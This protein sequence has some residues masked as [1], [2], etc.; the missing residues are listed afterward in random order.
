MEETVLTPDETV[1]RRP[2]TSV[3]LYERDAC[4]LNSM[5][6]DVRAL[7]FGWQAGTRQV[8]PHRRIA[9]KVHGLRHRIIVCVPE[10]LLAAGE[11]FVVGFVAERHLDLDIGPLEAANTRIVRNFR[12][13]PGIY[14][15][16]SRQLSTGNW[17]N[18]VLSDA[19]RAAENWRGCEAHARAVAELSPTY[20]QN[21]RI[22]SGRLPGGL[23][24]ARSVA[25]ERTRY[26]DYG[27]PRPWRA[28][29]EL[30]PV[31]G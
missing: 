30:V 21:V 3:A 1:A 5:L 28:V 7:M 8:L 26:V 24:G 6:E 16:S 9:W 25:I 27:S 12:D 15:Y 22:H 23:G 20:Y 10:A 29:R 4:I 13:Y 17:V 11:L 31:A 2:F 18:L 19:P 14:S